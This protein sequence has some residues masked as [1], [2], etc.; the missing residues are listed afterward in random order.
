MDCSC[1]APASDSEVN[2]AIPLVPA[3]SPASGNVRPVR[4]SWRHTIIDGVTYKVAQNRAERESAF[5]LIYDSYTKSGL[6]DPNVHRM[7]VTPYH[8]QPTTDVFIATHRNNVVYTLTLISDD[9]DGVPMQ[10]IYEEELN[11]RRQQGLYLAEISC[12]ASRQGY[13][14]PSRM[15]ETFVHLLGLACQYCRLNGVDRLV[16]A[17]HPRHFRFYRRCLGIQQ[18]G[19]LRDY[20]SVRNHPAVAGEH[21]F[22]RMDTQRYPLYDQIYGCRFQRWELLRQPMLDEDREYFRPAALLCTSYAP[23]FAA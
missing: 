12:L 7:R 2:P 4:R 19:E 10:S 17:I 1:F 6:M 8:L 11:Q 18:I 23:V 22:A 13:F 15:L 3:S 21:D 16:I 14:P 9:F 20:A 5:R